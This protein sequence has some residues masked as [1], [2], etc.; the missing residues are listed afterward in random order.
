V[1]EC[2]R[3]LQLP[4]CRLKWARPC[5]IVSAPPAR[6]GA[7]LHAEASLDPY[8]KFLILV[9]LLFFAPK[10]LSRLAIPS[11]V[12]EVVLGAILGPLVLRV[13]GSNEL[14]D[15]LA[16]I[17]ISALFLF[18][19]LEVE[20]GELVSRKGPLLQHLAIQLL[21]FALAAGVALAAGLPP[22]VSVLTAVGVMSPSAGFILPALEAFD[23]PR[24]AASWIQQKAIATE[25]LAIA[26]VLVFAN[27]GSRRDLLFGLGGIALLLAAL[28]LVFALFHLLILP[29]APRTELSFVT[30][31]ALGAA[32]LTHQ[33]GVHQLVGAFVVGL[34]ARRYLD[35]CSRRAVQVAPI[36]S[37]LVSLR[38]FSA[39][40]VPFFFFRVGVQ[41][42]EE[43]IGSAA[44]LLA[45]ILVAGAVPLRVAAVMFHRRWAL[46][47]SWREARNAGLFL[48]PTMV[49]SLAVAEILRDRFSAPGW[50]WAGLVVY[51]AA[52]TFLPLFT[53]QIRSTEYEDVLTDSPRE[54]GHL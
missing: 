8:L 3:I 43:A 22:A 36:R 27:T 26:A 11:P 53:R 49:F 24:E 54:M 31:L 18:A 52:T 41:L 28:P 12:T 45:V 39:F 1:K 23:L 13:A 35:W 51:G 37:A 48:G 38:F 9:G 14:L 7:G 15:A 2:V 46:R 25:L 29:T 21:L 10:V 33:L 6:G 40:F 30:V 42:P 19:G 4:D 34:A 47:E 20:A 44:L 17:G 5:A 50:L 16:G 32:Y